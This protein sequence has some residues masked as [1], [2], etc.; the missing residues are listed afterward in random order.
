MSEPD[1]H[2]EFRKLVS[3]FREQLEWR[4]RGGAFGA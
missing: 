3:G 1:L 4:A 2:D